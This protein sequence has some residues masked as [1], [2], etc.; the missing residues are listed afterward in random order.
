MPEN[1]PPEISKT[2]LT[3]TISGGTFR[4]VCMIHRHRESVNFVFQGLWEGREAFSKTTAARCGKISD[5]LI[6]SGTLVMD[7][8]HR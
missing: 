5:A 4:K 6:A 7:L 2:Y 8:I 3:E 1:Y